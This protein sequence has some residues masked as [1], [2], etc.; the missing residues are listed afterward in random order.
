MSNPIQKPVEIFPLLCSFAF[1]ACQGLFIPSYPLLA[2]QLGLSISQLIACFSFGSFLFIFGSPYWT[3][4]SQTMGIYPVLSIGVAGLGVSFAL[5]ASLYFYKPTAPLL[6][7][8]LLL[9][10]RTIYG[11]TASAIVPLCQSL[12]ATTATAKLKPMARHS[13]VLNIGR[14]CGFVA[15]VGFRDNLNLLFMVYLFALVSLWLLTLGQAKSRKKAMAH[16]VPLNTT[17]DF[18]NLKIPLL[19]AFLFTSF[20]EL[21]NTSLA[22]K[23]KNAFTLSGE[24]AATMAAQL[25]VI[26]SLIVFLAQMGLVTFVKDRQRSLLALGATLLASGS[27]LLVVLQNYG[28]MHIA[29]VLIALGIGLISPLNMAKI[30]DGSTA[31][32][33]SMKAG[34]ISVVNTLGFSV[35]G[36]FAAIALAISSQGPLYLLFIVAVALVGLSFLPQRRLA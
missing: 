9:L 31:D 25:F 8:A 29:I 3:K 28:Q 24:Q 6:V 32:H 19:V 20:I 2:L 34:W 16:S 33:H 35:G 23:L 27:L 18:R 21:L 26:A 13:M 4:K 15:V 30:F 14:L 12:M 5:V 7:F 11:F 22:F 17:L 36:A 1:S 10:S